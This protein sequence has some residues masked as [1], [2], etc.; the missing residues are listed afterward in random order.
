MSVRH[1]NTAL[2]LRTGK[3]VDRKRLPMIHCEIALDPLA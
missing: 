3:P 2:S 1:A